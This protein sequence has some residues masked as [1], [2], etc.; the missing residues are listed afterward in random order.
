MEPAEH[1]D[2]DFIREASLTFF[3]EMRKVL[4]EFLKCL[5]HLNDFSLH[6]WSDLLVELEFFNQKV[7]I[8]L[9]SLLNVLSDVVVELWLHVK[10]LV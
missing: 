7:E 9:I 5:S 2:D 8:I 4:F 3:E 10:R 6:S 1:V